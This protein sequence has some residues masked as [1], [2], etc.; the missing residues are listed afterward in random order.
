MNTNPFFPTVRSELFD[1][2]KI[3]PEQVTTEADLVEDLKLDSQ[4][5]HQ[6][7]MALEEVLS[8]EIPEQELSKVH[9]VGE[10]VDYLS[11]KAESQY[12]G[13]GL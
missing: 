11:N 1:V 13:Q 6:L 9:T 3:P 12:I 10:L 2:L 7:V 4:D 5:T 8:M